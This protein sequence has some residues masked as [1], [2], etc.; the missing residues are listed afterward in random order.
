MGRKKTN[1]VYRYF[2]LHEDG[3]STCTMPECGKTFKTHHGA[4]LLKHLKRI[5]EEEYTKVVDLNRSQEENTAIE[6]QNCTNSEIV[7]RECTNLVVVH[8]RPFSLMNDT[9]FQNLISLIPNSEATVN[10]QAIKDNVKLTASN[11][12]DELVNALQARST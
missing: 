5:H 10:A 9:A 6:L 7:L 8:G 4:N 12:R 1:T 3:T 2:E 11:I